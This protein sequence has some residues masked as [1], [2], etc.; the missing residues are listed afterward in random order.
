MIFLLFLYNLLLFSLFPFILIFYKLI[1]GFNLKH[2]FSFDNAPIC[3]VL[4]CIDC[5]DDFYAVKPLLDKLMV[6]KPAIKISIIYRNKALVG[7]VGSEFDGAVKCYFAPLGS[8]NLMQKFVSKIK[9]RIYITVGCKM[10]PNLLFFL[11]RKNI[12]TIVVDAKLSFIDK[13]FYKIFFLAKFL[14]FGN[15]DLLLTQTEE[16]AQ[17]FS[18]LSLNS[19]IF[20]CGSSLCHKSPS[21]SASNTKTSNNKPQWVATSVHPLELE[22]VILAHKLLL[23]THS[24]VLLFLF[25]ESLN[26]LPDCESIAKNH[27]LTYQL[28]TKYD[29]NVQS[30]VV[31]CDNLDQMYEFYNSSCSAFIGGSIAHKAS[32][33]LVAIITNS[34]IIMGEHYTEYQKVCDKLIESGGLLIVND[35]ISLS[36]AVINS[37]ADMRNKDSSKEVNLDSH[38]SVIDKYCYIIK[39]G[40]P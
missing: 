33:P 22:T 1:K 26:L 35:S 7:L 17:R 14:V 3:D 19:S 40:L 6:D 8:Y 27:S 38:K 20:S 39:S 29:A 10:Q 37:L 23:T 28:L 30:E 12:K 4:F 9:A 34:K 2:L 36:N 24:N 11:K 5:L 16:D 15:V 32:N 25:P 13:L 21:V 18:D 31:I